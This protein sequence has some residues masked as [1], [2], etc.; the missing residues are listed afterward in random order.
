MSPYVKRIMSDTGLDQDKAESVWVSAKKHIIEACALKNEADMSREHFENAYSYVFNLLGV[1]EELLDVGVFLN[2]G[3]SAKEF[4]ETMTSAPVAAAIKE[5]ITLL[6]T[7]AKD[8]SEDEEAE[9]NKKETVVI[10]TT[11]EVF[12]DE[13]LSDIIDDDIFRSI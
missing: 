6:P 9:K 11:P 12:I 4:V 8:D 5:P 1:K 10:P 7:L 2:S 13:D 3:K